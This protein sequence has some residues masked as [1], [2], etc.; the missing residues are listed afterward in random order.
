[1][2]LTKERVV[3]V[4][5]TQEELANIKLAA[6]SL[7]CSTSAYIRLACIAHGLAGG[8]EGD[9]SLVGISR[10]EVGRLTREMAA[11]GNN[12]NQ[13]AH[14]LNAAAA[15]LRQIE[16]V[17]D[18]AHTSPYTY[19]MEEVQWG[20]DEMPELQEGVYRLM[21]MIYELL[22]SRVVEV[23]GPPKSTWGAAGA[24]AGG[25]GGGPPAPTGGPTE[26]PDAPAEGGEPACP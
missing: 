1:M 11:W 7:G 2:G 24:Q 17:P 23:P 13:V 12:L 9:G 25:P 20:L 22:C 26:G 15:A 4:R 14:A 16:G 21:G 19:A 6:A 18:P 5:V 3:Y 8:A 10:R